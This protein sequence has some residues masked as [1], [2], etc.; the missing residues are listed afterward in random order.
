MGLFYKTPED[1]KQVE[2]LV[3]AAG[4]Q[5]ALMG[6]GYGNPGLLDELAAEAT[7]AATAA[8]DRLMAEGRDKD[9][10]AF[11]KHLLSVGG[12]MDNAPYNQLFMPFVNQSLAS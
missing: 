12:Y 4:Q 1:L 10:K 2:T 3:L 11:R 6:K 7:A 9:L 5:M 8:R